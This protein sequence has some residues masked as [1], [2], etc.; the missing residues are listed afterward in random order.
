MPT[1]VESAELLL[2]LYEL[3]RD[4]TM[5]A[6]REWFL[7]AFHPE[8]VDDVVAAVLGPD[9]PKFRMVLGYW[10]MA[11]S[12]VTHG[13]IDE[14]M[15]RDASAEIIGTFAKMAPFLAEMRALTGN[16]DY[17]RHTER[18]VMG[19]PDAENRMAVL[20]RQLREAGA[21]DAERRQAEHGAG[22]G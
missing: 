5:R 12:F 1:P 14:A 21:R 4:P 18:V 10:D 3:R 11:C 20:R 9:N 15:F 7:R 17:L 22:S 16:A 2:R 6:A 13:A 8:S 19:Y